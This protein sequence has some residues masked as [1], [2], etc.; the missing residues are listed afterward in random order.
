MGLGNITFGG[1]NIRSGA[2]TDR[3]ANPNPGD[4]YTAL[5]TG[6]ILA[7]FGKKGYHIETAVFT[8][9]I[10]TQ[11]LYPRGITFNSDGTKLFEVGAS[12]D[13][14]YE[15]ELTIA[16]DIST[17]TFTQSIDAQ[18]STPRGITFNSD[19]TKLFEVGT[20]SDKIYEYELTI[21]YDI[22]TATFTQSIDA[23][24]LDP[25]GL[26]FNNDGTKLFEVGTDSDKIY[27]YELTIAY[28]ISTATFTQSIDAQ[29]LDPRGITFNSDGT[30]LF[31]VG[32]DSDKIFEYELTIAYDISTATFKQSIDT[33]DSYPRGITFNSDGTKLYEVGTG[34]DK[35]YEYEL[36]KVG[37]WESIAPTEPVGT[38]K[39]FSG[40]QSNIPPKWQI[41]DGTNGTPDLR[42]RF[43]VGAG[44]TYNNGD[45][46]GESEHT[47]TV[48]EMP[49][50]NHS[51]IY[52]DY[53]SS[54]QDGGNNPYVANESNGTNYVSTEG[55][56]QPHEN[57]PPYYALYYIMKVSE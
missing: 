46:G 34:S 9:S 49:P 31:E 51:Y 29:D 47:L 42:N 28:D 14:I 15:Y 23:Q 6:E 57:R 50:H 7:C 18:D 32:T 37:E 8:Q 45:T 35:I 36:T 33:Q 54:A 3:P 44:D 10:D 19:G 48:G 5:D 12:S 30:K 4:W 38:I 40:H 52:D 1:N 13:K 11:D 43:V 20:G 16:Y 26:T 55:G 27:E 56:G 2:Y 17:A 22:S 21:A 53:G 25:T 41:C 24:D 39:M